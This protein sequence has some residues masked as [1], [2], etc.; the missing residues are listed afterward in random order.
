MK[1]NLDFENVKGKILRVPLSLRGWPKWLV[2]VLSIVGIGYIFLPEG[3][4]PSALPI[5]G[6]IDEGV[7]FL[8]VYY[9]ILEFLEP[10]IRTE[11]MKDVDND[12]VIDAEWSDGSDAE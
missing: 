12:D 8:M 6:D 9:G 7:A 2:W 3:I 11:L 4:I 5:I 10:Y 1:D